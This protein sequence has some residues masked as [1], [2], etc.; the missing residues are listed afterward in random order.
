M[1]AGLSPYHLLRVF[2]LELGLSPHSYQIQRRI[3]IAKTLLAQGERI[4]QVA[5]CTGF[6]DQS[7]LGRHFKRLVGVTPG[8]FAQS[9]TSS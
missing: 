9:A 1:V 8:Q 3:G 2:R 5:A 4:A 6:T 7:H